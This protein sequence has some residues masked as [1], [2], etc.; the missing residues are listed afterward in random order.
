MEEKIKKMSVEVEMMAKAGKDELKFQKA[1]LTLNQA[2]KE[3]KAM[4]EKLRDL[5]YSWVKETQLALHNFQELEEERLATTKTFFALYLDLVTQSLKDSGGALSDFT[6]IFNKT[7]LNADLIGFVRENQTGTARPT[8]RTTPLN[9]S[10]DAPFAASN[11]PQIS[12]IYKMDKTSDNPF[13]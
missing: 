12:N 1:S 7:D 10:S 11:K 8:F 2:M 4:N 3:M 9:I 5:H 13:L 6:A